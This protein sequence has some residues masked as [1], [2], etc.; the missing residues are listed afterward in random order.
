MLKYTVTLKT[1]KEYADRIPQ[2]HLMLQLFWILP[3][4]KI[5]R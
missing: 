2:T 3:L 5:L 4:R 1:W